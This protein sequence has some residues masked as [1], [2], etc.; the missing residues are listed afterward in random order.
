M[1]AM[2]QTREATAKPLFR[3]PTA[4]YIPW[5]AELPARYGTWVA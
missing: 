3:R 4:G 1:P 5:A 2:E